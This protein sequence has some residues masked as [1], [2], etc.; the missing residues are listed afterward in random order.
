MVEELE[1]DIQELLLKRNFKVWR[2]LNSWGIYTLGIVISFTVI[3]T[4]V[5]LTPL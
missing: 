1:H 4:L 2:P 3:Y 5:S